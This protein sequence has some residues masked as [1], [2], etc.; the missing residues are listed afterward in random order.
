MG[1]YPDRFGLMAALR[2]SLITRLPLVTYMHD[3]LSEALHDIHPVRVW[4]WRLI[5]WLAL[6]RSALI[7]V[8]TPH[9]A[10]RFRDRGLR[11]VMVLP[12]LVTPRTERPAVRRNPR[13][14]RIVYTGMIYEAHRQAVEAFVDTARE[15]PGVSLRF[16]TPA[17]DPCLAGIRVGPVSR[18][19]CLAMQEEADV[20]FLP[21]GLDTPYPLEVQGCLPSKLVDYL[22]AGKPILALVP[23]GSY[24]AELIDATQ[25]GLVV[26][27]A[28][29]AAIQ[30]A[31]E[32]LREADLRH[33]LGQNA[34][35]ACARFDKNVHIPR[36][37]RAIERTC[38]P[39]RIADCERLVHTGTGAENAARARCE[40]AAG[41]AR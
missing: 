30:E 7:L 24:V 16:A 14:L 12:H 15:D 37:V 23:A 4:W 25:S 17:A 31:I 20:L 5:E 19:E 1:V 34:L 3:Y 8:P 10:R 38:R 9:F 33:R 29:P 18:A 21:L 32:R 41:E 27:T 28:D 36:L 2:V 22:A 40:P 39:S 11:R 26:T 6:R 35:R 13:A